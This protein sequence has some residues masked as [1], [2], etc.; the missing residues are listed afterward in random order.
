[1]RF[2]VFILWAFIIFSLLFLYGLFSSV[3]P[4]PSDGENT[5]AMDSLT[6]KAPK[7][8]E[9]LGIWEVSH[10]VDD[11]GEKTDEKYITSGLIT[12]TFSNIITQNS[13][14]RARILIT[15]STSTW[16]LLYEYA[17]NNPVKKFMDSKYN[18]AVQDKDGE[19]YQLTGTNPAEDRIQIRSKVLHQILKKG[20]EVK[21]VIRETN[22]PTTIYKFEINNADGYENA[23]RKLV[24]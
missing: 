9:R 13:N 21:F 8:I 15:D 22:L 2:K 18:I 10:F 3:N 7:T 4:E 6:V 17:G 5:T 24:E 16:I 14:L 12:G 20:D 19:R 1:M 23:Y 11:F